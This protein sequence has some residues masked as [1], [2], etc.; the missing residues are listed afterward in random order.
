MKILVK[1]ISITVLMT[2][3]ACSKS[4]ENKTHDDHEGHEKEHKEGNKE[5]HKE[6]GDHNHDDHDKDTEA[7]DSDHAHEKEDD[8]AHEEGSKAV[9]VGKAI[10]VVDE[11]KGF[12]FNAAAENL[13]HLKFMEITQ[14]P[15][16]VNKEAL[17]IAKSE[18]GVYR[19]RQ[20][21]YKFIALKKDSKGDYSLSKGEFEVGDKLVTAGLDLLRISDVFSQDK[22]DYGHSH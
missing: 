17:V 2:M 19:A 16:K 1:I 11:K 14:L 5:E 10:E 12:K 7:H 4:G 15:L 20:S 22:S 9:G 21:F 13:M 6:E 18:I 8:H 3:V